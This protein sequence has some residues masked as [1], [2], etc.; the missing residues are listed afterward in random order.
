MKKVVIIKSLFF[1]N[2]IVFCAAL[3]L[4]AQEKLPIPCGN[5]KQLFYLQRTVNAN[6]LIYELNYDKNILNEQDPVHVYWIRY[7]EQG[8]KEELNFLQR[9]FAYG[10]KAAFISKDKYELRLVSCKNFQMFLSKGADNKYNVYATINQKQAI[11]NRIFVKIDGGS[12]WKPNVEYV[13][14]KGTDPS[15]G[16]EVIERLKI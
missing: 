4:A 1:F 10:I 9:K 6:T 8:Q 15:T 11:L 5:E 7:N 16:K 2:L 14:V 12:V 3:T 13:E